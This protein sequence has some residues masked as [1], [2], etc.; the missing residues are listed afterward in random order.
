MRLRKNIKG[1]LLISS[2]LL[3]LLCVAIFASNS[4]AA[5]GIKITSPLNGSTVT[6]G[7]EVTVKIEAVGGF[8]IKQ[9]VAGIGGS[10]LNVNVTS[11]PMT[12]TDKIPA[13]AI[14]RVAVDVLATDVAGNM[15]G[16][17]VTLNVQQTATLQSLEINQDKISV[18]LDWDGNINENP[19]NYICT[20]YGIY[21]DGIKRD[22]SEDANTTYSSNDPSVI[23]IDNKGNY[24]INK[25]GEATV[26]VSNS[27]LSKVI[28]VVFEKPSG[29][30]PSETIPP[31][32]SIDIQPAP[33]AA[34]WYNKDVTITITAK[35]NEGGSGVKDISYQFAYL[36]ARP[37]YINESQVTIPF[38]QE[39]INLFRYA[40][41]DNEGNDSGQQSTTIQLDKTPPEVSLSLDPYKIKLPFKSEGCNFFMP[42]FYKLSYTATDKV[43]G[44]KDIRGGLIIPDIKSFRTQLNRGGMTQVVLND[45]T[46]NIIITA[47]N[48][49]DL[50][51][52]LKADKLFPID[53][54]QI[55]HLN[56]RPKANLWTI[57]K[58]SNYLIIN[59]PS[60][61]FSAQA[62]DNADNVS[63]TKD[64]KYTKTRI[65]L[66]DYVKPL[67]NKK[68][69]SPEEIKD[70]EDDAV[71]DQDTMKTI[72]KNYGNT[73]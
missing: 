27:G 10:P 5:P 62:K 28:P 51:N 23:S 67:I 19:S 54:N 63:T 22:I 26:T 4:F 44:V 11:L 55:M 43:S 53:N 57:T 61:T 66:P 72:R 18:A 49:Q 15:V 2:V 42:F 8:K 60:I 36:N 65:P 69:L 45:R 59:A 29:I 16:D 24:T 20:V 21:S 71:I 30:R 31:T 7:Q 48:P 52:Q 17:S 32:V 9:G 64:I 6:P 68:E 40:A 35:D 1:R 38:S 14:G 50:L 33:N 12:F 39:G 13:K 34:G 46:K 41:D 3:S 73:R 56:E 47:P 25:V 70:L 58:L 37:T